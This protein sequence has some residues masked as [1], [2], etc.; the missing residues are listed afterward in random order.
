MASFQPT[1][2]VNFTNLMVDLQNIAQ[3][4]KEVTPFVIHNIAMTFLHA[5]IA[6]KPQDLEQ[7]TADATIASQSAMAPINDHIKHIQHCV[8]TAKQCQSQMVYIQSARD[9]LAQGNC[10]RALMEV[11]QITLG[12]LMHFVDLTIKEEIA[13]VYEARGQSQAAEDLRATLWRPDIRSQMEQLG[14]AS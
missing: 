10:E 14:L 13:S 3:N 9:F 2:P 11:H 6:L 12:A 5:L 7:I 4:Y 8:I 1:Y